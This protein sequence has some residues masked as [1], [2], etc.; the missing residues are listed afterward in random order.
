[1]LA[2]LPPSPIGYW[3]RITLPVGGDARTAAER[4]EWAAWS[5]AVDTRDPMRWIYALAAAL[6]IIV[7]GFI[8][9][10]IRGVV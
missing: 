9:L 6:A 5:G 2:A 7:I 10:M 4:Q 3:G 1:M 8:L